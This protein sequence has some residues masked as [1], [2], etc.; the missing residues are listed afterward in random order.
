VLVNE[1]GSNWTFWKTRIVPYLK[2]S[3][4][5]PT[6]LVL[7]QTPVSQTLRSSTNGKSRTHQALLTYPNEH[8]TQCPSG[9]DVLAQDSLG[10]S[11]S[12][13]S[14]PIP[15]HKTHTCPSA[16][17]T[18]IEGNAE[19]LQ[20]IS[21]ELQRLRESCGSLGVTINRLTVCRDHNVIYADSILGSVIGTLEEY[22]TEGDH[23]MFNTEGASDRVLL[24]AT[25]T[26]T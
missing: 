8:R 24:L 26:R 5:G 7:F 16:C 9:L 3:D 2:G 15:L 11:V 6:Y 25:K 4:Y 18:F 1:S 19:T 21:R 20:D 17:Q 14:Q 12:C 22:W 23:L 13:Y 10:Q